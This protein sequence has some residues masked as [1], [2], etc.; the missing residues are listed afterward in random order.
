MMVS[1]ITMGPPG[2]STVCWIAKSFNH[3]SLR[4]ATHSLR[5]VVNFSV[6]ASENKMARFHHSADVTA[7]TPWSK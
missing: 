3:F 4:L 1:F 2:S 6:S 7:I 5:A